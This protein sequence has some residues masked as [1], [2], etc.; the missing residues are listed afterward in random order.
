VDDVG[1]VAVFLALPLA[2]YVTGCIVVCDGG[3]N[4][5]GSALFNVGSA[6]ALQA[7]AKS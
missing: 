7:Q 6:Q 2:S 1:Q 3:Q 4:R 5:V